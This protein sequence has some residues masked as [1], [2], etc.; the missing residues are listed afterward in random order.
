MDYLDLARRRYSVRR[1]TDQPVEEEKLAAI[2]EAGRVAPTGHNSQPQRI[3]VVQS[4]AGLEK[5]GKAT[6]NFGAPVY[7]VVCVNADEAWTRPVDG[8]NIAETDAAIITDQMMMAAA[9]LGLGTC[10]QCHFKP[11][12]LRTEFAI[13]AELTPVNLLAVGYADT[14]KEAAAPTGR[15][16]IKRKPLTETVFFEGFG[17]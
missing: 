16:E 17:E 7:L 15:H 4:A 5:I 12:I 1:Y 2:L 8:K 3:L 14:E 11:E 10:W 9:D 13:P 6:K